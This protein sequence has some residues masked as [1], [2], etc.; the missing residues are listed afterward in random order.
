VKGLHFDCAEA[1]DQLVLAF[2]SL[3]VLETHF[4]LST[5]FFSETDASEHYEI[6]ESHCL[7]R[8][9]ARIKQSLFTS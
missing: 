8:P 7:I 6:Q 3:G 5:L 4:P 2:I 9:Q 1:D